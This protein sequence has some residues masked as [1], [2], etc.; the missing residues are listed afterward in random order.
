MLPAVKPFSFAGGDIALLVVYGAFLLYV[1][2]RIFG[3]RRSD[4]AEYLVA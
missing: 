2:L 4:A 1:T 3:P